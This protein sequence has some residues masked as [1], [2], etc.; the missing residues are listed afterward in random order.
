MTE[1]EKAASCIQYA[2]R[3]N[4]PVLNF[5]VLSFILG[6]RF[7]LRVGL[8]RELKTFLH[9]AE[10]FAGD[11]VDVF[12]GGDDV[13]RTRDGF[14]QLDSLQGVGRD[15]LRPLEPV[16]VSKEYLNSFV[17]VLLG[18]VQHGAAVDLGPAVTR[19]ASAELLGP[20]RLIPFED[21]MQDG[22]VLLDCRAVD[23]VLDH[24]GRVRQCFDLFIAVKVAEHGDE[25]IE[26]DLNGAADGGLNGGVDVGTSIFGVGCQEVDEFLDDFDLLRVLNA[27][28]HHLLAKLLIL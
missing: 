5:L 22:R 20:V 27:S 15:L 24:L 3:Q 26:F 18:G 23:G 14:E 17:V 12:Q 6:R 16:A 7:G 9:R 10:K 25:S 13:G 11:V 19:S 28:R 21:G 1:E 2:C 8:A 4:E